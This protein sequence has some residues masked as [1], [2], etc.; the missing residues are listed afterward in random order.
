M[1]RRLGVAAATLRTW[2]RRY[3]LGPS[4]HATGAHR[5]YLP[6]DVARLE[7]M[8]RL[9]L[10]GVGTAEAARLAVAGGQEP[11]L[12]PEPAS[13]SSGPLGAPEGTAAASRGLDRAAL[14]M[15]ARAVRRRARA[16]FTGHGLAAGWQHVVCPALTAAGTRWERTGEGVEV[17]HLLAES[18]AAELAR[19]VGLHESI[20]PPEVLL[21]CPDGDYHAL[22]LHALAAALAERGIGCRLLGGSVPAPALAAAITRT[23][24]AVVVL[25]AQLAVP[26]AAEVLGAVP[27]TRPPVSLVIGGPGWGTQP[28]GRA[29]RVAGLSEAVD[30]VLAGLGRP[31]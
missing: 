31:A 17:E 9:L 16:A 23:G 7:L 12:E 5:R 27:L 18:V 11:E 29:T 21:A 1:A 24:P 15:D 26:D 14:A 19:M 3:G 28:S 2:D 30:A 10:S 6:P 25:Y 20:G 4:G 22:P 13:G 8:R